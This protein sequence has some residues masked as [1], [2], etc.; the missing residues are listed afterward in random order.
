M[1]SHEAEFNR[2]L[3]IYAERVGKSPSTGDTSGTRAVIFTSV[4]ALAAIPAAVL[5]F[6]RRREDAEAV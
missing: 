5:T 1:R 4:A 6:R 3:A 2:R